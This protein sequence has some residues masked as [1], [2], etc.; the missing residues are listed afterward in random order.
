MR[1]ALQMGRPDFGK[2]VQEISQTEL[3]WWIAYD[4]CEPFGNDWRRTARQTVILANVHG[5]KLTHDHED[6][7]IPGWDPTEL[8]QT[9]EQMAAILKGLNI[10]VSN[11]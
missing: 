2:M 11:Q 6:Q 4:A 3:E 5:A 7:M 10:D 1:L 8:K 9:P